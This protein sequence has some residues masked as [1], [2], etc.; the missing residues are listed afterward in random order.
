[1]PN[2]TGRSRLEDLCLRR[3]RLAHGE[4]NA[5]HTAWTR[6][7]SDTK[8]K[9]F[10][11]SDMYLIC[12]DMFVLYKNQNISKQHCFKTLGRWSKIFGDSREFQSFTS[13][14]QLWPSTR[15]TRKKLSSCVKDF[16]VPLK[17]GMSKTDCRLKTV[18]AMNVVTGCRSFTGFALK[19]LAMKYICCTALLLSWDYTTGQ[20]VKSFKEVGW[21]SWRYIFH[22][23]RAQNRWP[24]YTRFRFSISTSGISTRDFNQHQLTPSNN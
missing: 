15:P 18:L 7:R 1:M 14:H 24:F 22:D 2:G 13:F 17:L 3:H 8:Q 5:G 20:V 23:D 6:K 16:I 21:W 12:M 9:K 11:I 19:S 10:D 4:E